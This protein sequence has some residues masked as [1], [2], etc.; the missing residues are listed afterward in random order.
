MTDTAA[1]VV[2]LLGLAG[3]IGVAI[4]AARQKGLSDLVTALQA[5]VSSLRDQVGDNETRIQRL[6][7]R[8]RK[9]ADYVHILRAHIYAQKPPPPPEWP[10]ELDR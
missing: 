9:W 7:A 6:E 3:T 2:A 1:L 5:E 10:A 8:D 4:L